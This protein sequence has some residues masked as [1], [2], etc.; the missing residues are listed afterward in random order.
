M[1]ANLQEAKL[2]FASPGHYRLLFPRSPPKLSPGGAALNQAHPN[3]GGKVVVEIAIDVDPQQNSRESSFG[4]N[5][6][7]EAQSAEVKFIDEQH[8]LLEPG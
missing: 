7:T 2:P 3:A 5:H 1:P 4:G 6:T 8:R